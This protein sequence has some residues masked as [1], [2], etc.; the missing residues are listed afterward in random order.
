MI[1]YITEIGT[2]ESTTA[3]WSCATSEPLF[4]LPHIWMNGVP[5]GESETRDERRAVAA[6]RSQPEHVRGHISISGLDQFELRDTGESVV[7]RGQRAF[8][9]DGCG[10]NPRLSH[11]YL[12]PGRSP[13]APQA[14]AGVR[15]FGIRPDGFILVEKSREFA[16]S[17]FAPAVGIS[18]VP[19]F[20]K[21][22]ERDDRA[23]TLNSFQIVPGSVVPAKN[24]GNDVGIENDQP[25][26][27]IGFTL[28]A[29][30]YCSNERVHVEPFAS[31]DEF[32]G[33]ENLRIGIVPKRLN[34]EGFPQS[35][36][37]I[38]QVLPGCV[39]PQ[40]EPDDSLA[41]AD[42]RSELTQQ[43][44]TLSPLSITIPF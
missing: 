4:F 30:T 40:A 11:G 38:P 36:L 26:V 3:F 2:P 10:R 1:V 20:L 6:A 14:G 33:I 24:E 27:P 15:Q 12:P 25:D 21:C 44:L 32:L 37:R 29:F 9:H 41:V 35:G 39:V 23:A 22:L 8:Q 18:P 7:M 13:F 43:A 16:S 31:G 19:H 34:I 17:P 42:S 5:P 28:P